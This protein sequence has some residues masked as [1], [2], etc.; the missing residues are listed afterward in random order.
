MKIIQK[1][2]IRTNFTNSHVELVMGSDQKIGC[3]KGCEA[4]GLVLVGREYNRVYSTEMR[5]SE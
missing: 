2:I 1:Y 4:V 5:N 3:F